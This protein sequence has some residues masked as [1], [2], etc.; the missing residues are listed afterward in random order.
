M[1]SRDARQL[2]PIDGVYPLLLADHGPAD[3]PAREVLHYRRKQSPQAT[4]LAQ[5]AEVSCTGTA[6]VAILTLG[7]YVNKNSWKSRRGRGRCNEK[8]GRLLPETE[9]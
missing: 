9:E 1:C 5:S 7:F 3:P 4:G 6:Q 2:W 8:H